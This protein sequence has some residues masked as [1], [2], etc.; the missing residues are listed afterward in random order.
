MLTGT[1]ISKHTDILRSMSKKR[2]SNDLAKLYRMGFL[3]RKRV[4][5]VVRSERGRR[6]SRGYE[7]R[8]HVTNKGYNY[9]LYKIGE[10]LHRKEKYTPH[11]A[12]KNWEHERAQLG[13]YKKRVEEMKRRYDTM[14]FLAEH[15]K[16]EYD[17]CEI[18]REMY[19]KDIEK[20]RMKIKKLSEENENF[21]EVMRVIIS[22]LL[23]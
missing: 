12:H 19:V 3:S 2:I 4:K 5:R 15:Y 7:F 13:F 20:L 16:K 1:F 23:N 11:Y 14:E 6:V 17:V 10:S 9:T 22:V 8:Y 21:R 18:E